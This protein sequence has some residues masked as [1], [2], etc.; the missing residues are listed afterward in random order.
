MHGRLLGPCFKTGR[1]ETDLLA[2]PF[3]QAH[4]ASSTLTPDTGLSCRTRKNERPNRHVCQATAGAQTHCLPDSS[5]RTCT[6]QH[7]RQ[8]LGPVAITPPDAE[9]S[10]GH[11]PP[12]T[13]YGRSSHLIGRGF[14]TGGTKCTAATGCRLRQS[15]RKD[16]PCD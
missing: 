16:D 4:H 12:D 11:L 7:A 3:A 13:H 2:P 1:M 8:R 15:G 6:D 9:A 14:S 5:W 10:D